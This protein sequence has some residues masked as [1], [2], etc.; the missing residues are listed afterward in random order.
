MPCRFVTFILL[1]AL[2]AITG[3]SIASSASAAEVPRASANARVSY[4][5]QVR[6]ILVANCQGC[7]QPTNASGG[8]VM[9]AFDKL[10]AGGASR[11]AAI[12]PSHPE[13]SR[14][15]QMI[16]PH[17]GKAAMPLGRKPL[18]TKEIERIRQWIAQGAV[19][20]S[21]QHAK[22]RF[23][24]AHPPVYTRPAVITSLDFS[25]DGKLLAVSGFYEVLLLDTQSWRPVARLVGRSER[26]QSVRFSPDG[27]R[28]AV[29]GGQ[30]ARMGEV[31]VWDVARRKLLLSAPVTAD[32]LYGARWSPDGKRIAFGCG[33]NSV[34]AIDAQTGKQELFM[35]SHTDWALDT[36]FSA[37]GS[38]LISVGRDMTAKLTE[39]ATQRFVDNITSITPGALKGGIASVDRHPQRDEIVIGGSDGVP[40]V[41][42]VHRQV[43]RR[44]GDDS[45]LIR[46]LTPMKGRVFSVAI[47]RDGK[48][49]AAGSSLD[50]EGY[51]NISSYEFD[52]GLPE[53]IKKIMAKVS[54]DRKPEEREE[55]ER[56]HTE[57]VRLIASAQ[58]DR[59]GIYAVAFRP[60]GQQV[61]AGGADGTVR[62][63][64]AANGQVVKTFVPVPITAAP[65]SALRAPGSGQ[66]AAAQRRPRTPAVPSQ[67]RAQRPAPSAA[68][69]HVQPAAIQLRGQFDY[70]QLQ[71]TAREKTSGETRDV[72]RQVQAELSNAVALVTREGLVRPLA[73]GKATLRLRQSGPGG[74]RSTSVSVPVTVSG[75]AST[76][77]VDFVR[78]VA[79]VL[80]RLGCNAGTCHGSAQGKNGFK[81]SLRGYDPVFDARALTDDL[82]SRRI[83][84]ASPDDSLMLLKSSGR[85]PHFGGPVMRP[86]DRYYQILRQWIAQGAL[87]TRSARVARI[88]VL[89]QN[90]VVAKIGDG[91]Q[92]RVRATY[93]DGSVRDVT[94][95]AFIESG[96]TEVATADRTARMTAVR[97][98]EA[99]ILARFEGAYTA[100]TLTVMG[101]RTGFVWKQPPANNRIDELVAAKWRRMK[102]RPSELCSDAEFIRRVYL[103][104]TGLPPTADEVR[105]FLAD[106]RPSREKRNAVIDR[107]IGSKEWVE[108]WTNK[109][110]DLLQVNRKFLDVEGAAAFRKWIRQEVESNTPYDQFVRKILTASGSNRENPGASYYKILREPDLTMENTTH[111]FLAVRFNCTKC[112]D[113][114]FER[115]TQNQYYSL[116]AYFARVE[117]KPDPES[118]DRRIGGT[119]VEGA[120]PLYEIVADKGEGEV[121]HQRTGQPA[122]PVF[123]YPST[124]EAPPS[125]TRRERL[126]AWVTS[127]DNPY[128]ARSYANRIWGYLMGLGLIEPIDDVRAGNPP[129][130]PELLDYLTEE[131][132]KSGFD[133]R[134][135]MRL[136]C[137]SRTYQ[138]SVATNRWNEDDQINFSHAMARRLPAEVLLDSVYRVTGAQ[139]KFPGV[140]P[141]TRAAELPDSGVELPSG[142]LTTLGRPPRESACECER[143]GGLQLGPVMALV[144]GPTIAEAIADPNNEI[145]RLAGQAPDDRKWVQEL[146]LRVLNRPATEVEIQATLKTMGAIDVDH[147]KLVQARAEREAYWAP[148][149][150]KLEKQREENIARAKVELAA[151]E[152]ELAPRLVEQ[153]KQKQEKTEKLAAE[154]AAYEKETLAGK[155]AEWEK[156]S[157]SSV[158]WVKLDPQTLQANN[159]TKLAKEAD[160]SVLVTDPE[161]KGEYTFEVS[162]D[163]KEITG[164]RLEALADPRLPKNG[165]GRAKDG[166]FVLTEFELQ[167]APKSD[168]GQMQKVELQNALAD[169]SQEGYEVAKAIDND[170]TGGNGW[171]VY[172]VFGVTHWAT[173]E[174]KEPI[175][176]EGGTVLR[177]TLHQ[178]FNDKEFSIGR[179]R[180]SITTAPRPVGVGL[181]DE[182]QPI[183]ATP[184]AQRTEAQRTALLTYYRP[185]DK[186]Y[187]EKLNAVE[188]SKKPLPIDPKLKELQDNLAYYNRPV[189]LDPLLAQLRHDV[190]MSTK[191]IADR[192]LTAAQDLAWALINSPAFL[193]NH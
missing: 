160:L 25:P 136:V 96:N 168:P 117:L 84:V 9:T 92:M 18:S 16:T 64:D 144:S 189:Q 140:P 127:K 31:Q 39:V 104:L 55:L 169:F 113:H 185:F 85:V 40:M 37:D 171:A 164:I 51:V 86:G 11:K 134:H 70:A 35:G 103:D 181:A 52:T 28:L 129:T 8:Y 178:K 165:P 42:R 7:H 145:A 102:I 105:A 107:L 190:E 182:L 128:F 183:L 184:E 27:A 143:A 82:A 79:P 159:K 149:Q 41:Y 57:G 38:H 15:V 133:V 108:Y 118:G 87:L 78:D 88:E 67:P 100:T 173:L 193:F 126:A 3:D 76:R 47:S 83:N 137:Q 23:D 91:Q 50:G 152:K 161:G 115:W 45:N 58:I 98:G 148:L 80:S 49:I 124:V 89:P 54:T 131:F 101:D 174:P 90:P 142:F 36:V 34:R 4:Y 166:N 177:F 13:K 71:V 123:P 155:V 154:L 116:A 77:R 167:A 109:W 111:L 192:R 2:I 73:D 99:P 22:A 81:L 19:D 10:L 132:L 17:E 46:R 43:D 125:A 94:R 62:L 6:P 29:T 110:A 95:E 157:A 106:R 60:D 162:T 135:V 14:L 61:A 20:D 191:Q 121:M 69:L 26:I 186:E 187:R 188:E 5:E 180:I 179:F 130:N 65:R 153:E 1:T 122:P 12:V 59:S 74:D 163:L 32:T 139:S 48:R 93:T 21:R 147:R 68:S 114:P 66:T 120:K 151:Y 75:M 175:A 112:H 141:G 53:S 156:K 172:P 72:T 170:R 97:R 63:I 150:V 158:A 138:L 33:D 119:A 56:Y 30:P 176:F 24:M 146:F 44:I